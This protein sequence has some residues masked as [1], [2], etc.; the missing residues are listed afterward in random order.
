MPTSV[1]SPTLGPTGYSIPSD[2]DILT[3]VLA[4]INSAFG[5]N[6]NTD[7]STPQGQLATSI[8]A[9]ISNCY[10]QFLALVSQF[11]PIYAQGRMQDAIGAL[12]SITRFPATSTTISARC[13]GSQG[14]VIPASI[15]LLVDAAGNKY[16]TVG[17]V[18][19]SAGYVDLEFTNQTAGALAYEA[20]ITI[21]Q[22]VAGL[23]SVSNVSLISTGTDVETQQA[24]E[25]RRQALLAVKSDGMIASMR[26]A[27]LSIAPSLACA[28]A[29]NPSD[30]PATIRGVSLP[31]N[32]IYI[33]VG[34]IDGVIDQALGFQI[35]QA[36]YSKK[37]PGTPYAVATGPYYATD[38]TLP[39]PKPTYPVGFVEPTKTSIN[40][41]VSLVAASNPPGD[42]ALLVQQAIRKAFTGEDGGFV[43]VAIDSLI[44]GTIYSSQFY[45][46]VTA[47]LPTVGVASIAI[48]LSISPSDY[49][50][51]LNL[52]QIPVLG[53]ISVVAI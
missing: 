31:A 2:A 3:G 4:D 9:I 49:V 27:I 18:I 28:I 26:A 44:G 32:S 40:F 24:F 14:T 30:S 10:A 21:Y 37:V 41:V 17:G 47:A 8:T 45:P 38:S 39:D 51:E 43:D 13:N 35:S 20:P 11:D 12:Y 19:T 48:G 25:Y 7:L 22:S 53:S 34:V 33:S 5:G 16:Q 42:A 15:A 46:A 1:P 6:L 29:E 50:L 52:D 36:I 23:S